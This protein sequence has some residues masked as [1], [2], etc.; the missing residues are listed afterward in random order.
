MRGFFAALRMT[1]GILS[2]IFLA[3]GSWASVFFAVALSGMVMLM[4]LR[5]EL[6]DETAETGSEESEGERFLHGLLAAGIA[7]MQPVLNVPWC[8]RV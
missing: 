4:V 6:R 1:I 8:S 5:K 7:Q 3:A 2:N